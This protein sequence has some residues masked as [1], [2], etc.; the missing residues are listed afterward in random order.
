MA[1]EK[2][3]RKEDIVPFLAVF[4]PEIPQNMAALIRLSACFSSKLVIIRPTAFVWDKALISRIAMDYIDLVK[5]VFFDSFD[6]FRA[7]HKGRILATAIGRGENYSAIKYENDD[8]ILLGKESTGL[9]GNIYEKVD[10][11]IT[12]PIDARSLNL[13]MAG[14]ILLARACDV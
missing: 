10:S 11:I 1:I 6:E 13:A 7:E 2:E 9:P 4:E 3:D 8:C 12:I 5:I 14:G